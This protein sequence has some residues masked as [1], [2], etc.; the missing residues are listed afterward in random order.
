MTGRGLFFGGQGKA[1]VC[2]V[3]ML[4]V[5]LDF[6]EGCKRFLLVYTLCC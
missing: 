2:F 1:A 3:N 4:A 5:L 6:P